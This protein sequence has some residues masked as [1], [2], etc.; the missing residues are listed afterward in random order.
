MRGT[1]S[2]AR[3]FGVVG[4]FIIYGVYQESVMTRTF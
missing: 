2:G 1:C 3:A 4:I